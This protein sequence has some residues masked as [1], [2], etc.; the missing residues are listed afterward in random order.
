M[1]YSIL[2]TRTADEQDARLHPSLTSAEKIALEPLDGDP[3]LLRATG[4]VVS[5]RTRGDL[6]IH[7]RAR[8]SVDLLISD[9]RV[10]VSCIEPANHHS[11]AGI[12]ATLT[13]LAHRFG[14]KHSERVSKLLVGQV[15][16]SWLRC[17]GFKPRRGRRSDGELRLG[18][19]ARAP[20]GAPRELFLDLS[21]PR[22]VDAATIAQ[23]VATRA[24]RYLTYHVPSDET[25]RSEL[26]MLAKEMHLEPPPP[27]KFA[28]WHLP[29]APFVSAASA[30]PAA[31]APT[32]IQ[33]A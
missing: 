30:Y 3:L 13:H 1:D 27:G 15:R 26:Q 24:A 25:Q 11:S 12:H 33:R 16:Y 19:V 5:E 7:L 28:L 18:V 20:D 10:A 4:L 14:T 21:L 23:S 8:V 6:G 32:E 17:V 22:S 31:D 29:G 2:A 9:A